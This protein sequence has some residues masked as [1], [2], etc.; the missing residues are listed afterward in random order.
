[1]GHLKIIV[2][3]CLMILVDYFLF[4][5][6]PYI[7][8]DIPYVFVYL[9]HHLCPSSLV[10]LF[11]SYFDIKLYKKFEAAGHF[12]NEYQSISCFANAKLHW[13][14]SIYR[15]ISLVKIN[16]EVFLANSLFFFS[17]ARH[18][19]S[20]ALGGMHKPCGQFFGPF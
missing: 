15:N 3:Y 14:L 20:F 18:F 7:L 6:R 16:P 13:I 2:I 12:M 11:A 8:S 1:M 10:Q 5:S 19:I 9:K 4:L 17:S